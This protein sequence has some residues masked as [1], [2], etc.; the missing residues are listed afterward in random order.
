[1]VVPFSWQARPSYVIICNQ[2]DK[3]INQ[4]SI[5]QLKNIIH[6]SCSSTPLGVAFLFRFHETA[7]IL[8]HLLPQKK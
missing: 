4:S 5:H 7:T 3:S 2:A 1:M 6:R 8:I